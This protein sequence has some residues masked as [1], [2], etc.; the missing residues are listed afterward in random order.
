MLDRASFG[1]MRKLLL[2]LAAAGSLFWLSYLIG[3]P[4][5]PLRRKLGCCDAESAPA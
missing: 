5:S 2:A 1:S 3:C 4:H